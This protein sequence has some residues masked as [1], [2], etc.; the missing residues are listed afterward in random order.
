MLRWTSVTGRHPLTTVRSN[1][2]FPQGRRVSIAVVDWSALNNT[3]RLLIEP[4]AVDDPFTAILDLSTIVTALIY[5][6][7]LLVLNY[8]EVAQR[9][10]DTFGLQSNV[11]VGLPL[12]PPNSK[13]AWGQPTEMRT[14]IEQYYTAAQDE[15]AFAYRR[16]LPW[17]ADLGRRWTALL[18]GENR[19]AMARIKYLHSPSSYERPPS[20]SLDSL[21]TLRLGAWRLT[22]KR[23][24]ELIIDNDSRSLFYDILL[25]QL[26]QHLDK[27]RTFTF[28]YLANALRSPMQLAR[29]HYA[30]QLLS[31]LSPAPEDWLQQEWAKL[32]RPLSLDLRMPFWLAAV[33]HTARRGKTIPDAVV[34]L[35]DASRGFRKHRANLE[36][37][38][39]EGD[40]SQYEKL[41]AALQGQVA[42]LTDSAA[43]MA[44]TALEL[45]DVGVKTVLPVPVGPKSVAALATAVKPN[46]FRERWLRMFRPQLWFIYDLGTRA[47]HVTNVMPVLAERLQ[48]PKAH[49]EE[50]LAFYDRLGSMTTPS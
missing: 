28:R 2:P 48:L 16:N 29:A 40:L 42:K 50:P 38:L 30:E 31:A 33:L 46:W 25:G 18:P 1:L 4:A 14:L 12:Q 19:N 26:R 32:Y 35:R 15:L 23:R 10:T 47:R 45:A 7:H 22:D 37:Q 49:A 34:E 8:G 11:I 39:F 43:G 21:F 6:D 17:V 20:R 24:V 36:E 3:C 27:Q 41:R 5:Y 44:N 9:A 13:S